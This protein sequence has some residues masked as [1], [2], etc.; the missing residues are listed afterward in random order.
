MN[1]RGMS[2]ITAAPSYSPHERD[3]RRPGYLPQ[4]RD[5]RRPGLLAA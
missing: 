2:A 4:E 1:A 5:N 3:S